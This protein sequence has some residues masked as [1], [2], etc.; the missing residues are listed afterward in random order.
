MCAAAP[1]RADSGPRIG[2]LFAYIIFSSVLLVGA[3]APLGAGAQPRS[4]GPLDR[5]YDF[6]D[7]RM[8]KYHQGS[9]LRLVQSYHWTPTFND[10]DISYT[11][12]DTVMIIALLQR[13]EDDDI[14]RA[15]VLGDSLLY[16]QDH[17][18]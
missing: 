3:I 4:S 8:D 5:A 2:L 6:L 18:P 11:Y 12:D 15:E 1:R 17:D 16:A 14:R 9:T 13:G 7:R 10:G